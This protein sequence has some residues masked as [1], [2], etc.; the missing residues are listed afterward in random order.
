M[1]IQ[2]EWPV[3]QP[4]WRGYQKLWRGFSAPLARLPNLWRDHLWRGHFVARLPS[5]YPEKA[6]DILT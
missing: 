2:Q 4:L 1:R 6:L 5:C 3:T